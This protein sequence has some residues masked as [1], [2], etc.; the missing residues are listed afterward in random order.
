[1]LTGFAAD[2]YSQQTNVLGR[3]QA[4]APPDTQTAASPAYVVEFVNSSGWIYGKNGGLIADFDL[5]SLFAVPAAYSFSDPRI[6]Y[7]P[8]ST[9]WFASGLAFNSS[10]Q[11]Q[12]Y[13][14][15]SSSSDPGGTWF[16]YTAFK[17]ITQLGD[18]PRLGVST[19]KVMLSWDDFPSNNL[20]TGYTGE[21][22]RIIQKS[23]LVAGSSSP[24]VYIPGAP[25]PTV[26]AM[27]PAASNTTSGDIYALYNDSNPSLVQNQSGPTLAVW[28]V[29]GTVSPNTV[30]ITPF[31]LPV[32]P[33]SAPPNASQPGTSVQIDTNDDRILGVAFSAGRLWAAATDACLPSG[34][35]VVRSCLRLFEVST[36][37]GPQLTQEFDTGQSGAYLYFPAVAFDGAGD[38]VT[39]FTRSSASIY[40]SVDTAGQLAGTVETLTAPMTL[41]AGQ[42]TF[43]NGR[44]GDYSGAAPDPA[45]PT[46]VWV[47]GEYEPSTNNGADWGTAIARLTFSAPAVTG[48]S[49][50]CGPSGTSVAVSG[51]DFVAGGTTFAFGGTA[52]GAV[53]VQSP[54]TVSVVAPGHPNGVV[55]VEATTADGTS[56]ATASDQFQYVSSGTVTVV[57]V[58]PSSGPASGG[59]QVTIAGCGFTGA[60]AVHFGAASAAYTVN[61]DASITAT[62]PSGIGSVDI[63]VTAGGSTSATS[64]ADVYTYMYMYYLSWY[65]KVSSPGLLADNIHVVN[66]GPGPASVNVWIPGMPGCVLANQIIAA[67]GEQYF[68]CATGYGGPV[69]ISSATPVLASQR[70][71]YY[72]TFNEVPAQPAS[73]ASNR[74]YLSWY[75]LQTPGFSADNI[76]VVNPGPDTTAVTVMIPGCAPQTDAALAAGAATYFSC[77]G[78][79]GGPVNVDS[80]GNPVLASQRVLYRQ[81]FNEV[82]AQPA[83]AASETLDL[84][85]YD[86][87]N[88]GFAVD[89]VHVINPGPSTASVTVAIPG[90]AL[91]ND[92]ALAAGT[93]TFFSC[94]GGIGGPVTIASTGNAVL[95]SQRVFF[96]QSFNEVRAPAVGS[97]QPA[98]YFT[99]YD[100]H[101]PGFEVDNIHVLNPGGT[102]VSVQVN[103]PGC[104]SQNDPSLPAGQETFFNCPGAIGGPVLVTGTGGSVLASQRVEYYQSFNEVLGT[105]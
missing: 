25:D 70:V 17:S 28:K 14:G 100:Q 18:Q 71:L 75:D 89:N 3:D 12:E 81:T 6:V 41:E 51:A 11:S 60:S 69:V 53:N 10:N 87:H 94:A 43:T 99:W 80:S 40:A 82:P 104:A 86:L 63:T 90:C 24:N 59:N 2:S 39:V 48:L 15:V 29:T 31:Y 102:P 21:E 49:P 20:S 101:S 8:L 34:D 78:G 26:Y 33:T 32:L 73:A 85:W 42:G 74:L 84:S 88:T 103:I 16:I 46:D 22:E 44:W 47:A 30:S 68:S 97:A 64:A 19:D 57:A 1:M 37:N 72:Q 7:D 76:H 23:D 4:V 52:V 95:A 65:D 83:S 36:A 62:A 27:V 79:Y 56:A 77:P 38:L 96:Q 55:D 93:E 5:N 35:N 9:R 67:D 54:D 98:L 58:T 105:S 66:P 61:S 91:Q 13:V 92:A 45:N 50:A